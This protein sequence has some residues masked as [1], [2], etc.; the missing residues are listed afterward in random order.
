YARSYANGE[1]F[2]LS[3]NDGSGFQEVARWTRGTDFASNNTFYNGTVTLNAANFS[4]GSNT[5]FRFEGEGA[6]NRDQVYLDQITI[7]GIVNGAVAPLESG[8]STTNTG[9]TIFDDEED[10]P[11]FSVFPNPA[12]LSTTLSIS[13]EEAEVVTVEV[14]T[15]TGQ[16]VMTQRMNLEVGT[17]ERTLDISSLQPGM[18]L[19]SVKSENLQET[20]RLVVE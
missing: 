17:H 10:A 7:T 15:I 19:V 12:K 8:Q 3:V 5:Q 13:M 4:F 2:T 6:A 1:Y 11:S 18:Y 9:I 14:L 16:S 20:Q